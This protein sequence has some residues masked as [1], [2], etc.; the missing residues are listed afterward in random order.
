MPDRSLL[1]LSRSPLVFALPAGH[2]G[3]SGGNIYNRNLLD[4]LGTVVPVSAMDSAEAARAFRSGRPATYLFDTLDLDQTLSLPPAVEDQWLCLVVH[5]LQSLEP[6]LPPEHPPLKLE[7]QAIRRFDLLVAT[8]DFTRAWLSE[9]GFSDA[10]I[11]VVPP[12]S[13]VAR[14]VPRTYEGP[15]SALAVANLIPRKDVLSLLHGLLDL[16]PAAYSLRIIGRTDVDPSYAAQCERV[17]LGSSWLGRHVSLEGPV[18]HATLRNIYEESNLFVSPS[19]ME[20]FGM[21]LQEARVHGLP[22]LARDGGHARHHL[23]DGE[24]GYLASTAEDLCRT[25][26]TLALDTVKMSR[27]FE[28]AQKTRTKTDYSWGTAAEKLL[29]A[30]ARL[31]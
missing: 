22:I 29:A 4:A 6:D 31:G 20:T 16:G 26:V 13:W 10:R 17:V 15:L 27:L 3:L 30:L 5:H 25:L 19:R 7:A 11:A 8:S 18:P 24:T 21:A 12:A 28:N 14:G 23:V 1:D 2:A 9:R